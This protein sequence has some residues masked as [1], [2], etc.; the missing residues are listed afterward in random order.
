MLNLDDEDR[1][2]FIATLRIGHGV[3]YAAKYIQVSPKDISE[4]I[5]NNPKFKSACIE[6]LKNGAK[7][8]VNI[9][10][11][12]QESSNAAK[13]LKV[14]EELKGYVTELILWEQHCKKA[15]VT[16]AMVCKATEIYKNRADC[17]TALGMTEQ[18]FV[19][20]V[21]N[22]QRLGIYLKQNKIYQF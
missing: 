12:H 7:Y 3:S 10:L 14:N 18:E 6:E 13:F 16:E 8:L 9:S 11:K 2:V 22:N 20:F 15:D 1:K 21:C 4:Y 17:A 5:N 19:E